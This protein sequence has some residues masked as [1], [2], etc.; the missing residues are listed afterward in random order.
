MQIKDPHK[1][2]LLDQFNTNP[3]I[4]FVIDRPSGTQKIF[5]L[6]NE[7]NS[8][9]NVESKTEF[10]VYT[11]HREVPVILPHFALY[12]AGELN[13]F[14]G[15]LIATDLRSLS[16]T[17]DTDRPIK[18]FYLYDIHPL[19]QLSPPQIQYLKNTNVKMFTRNDMYYKTL[20]NRGFS[21]LSQTVDD[22]NIK[23]IINICQ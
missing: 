23:Q 6:F 15:H 5:T 18:Y 3:A 1:Y 11:I 12:H 2:F 9:L 4:A 19:L 17:L 21:L 14:N 7:I 20:V 16:Y 8:H 22:F 10:S 13:D